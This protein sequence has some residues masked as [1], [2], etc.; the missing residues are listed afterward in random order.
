MSIDGHDLDV[1][2]RARRRKKRKGMPGANLEDANE[3]EVELGEFEREEFS[4]EVGAEERAFG[5]RGR[6]A[7]GV[8]GVEVSQ[9]IRLAPLRPAIHRN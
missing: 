3:G 1:G 6:E 4:G 2:V 8:I 9:E 7:F 5:P